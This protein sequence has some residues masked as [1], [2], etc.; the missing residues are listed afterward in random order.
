MFGSCCYVLESLDLVVPAAIETPDFFL[1]SIRTG[2]EEDPDIAEKQE[3][4][5]RELADEWKSSVPEDKH[6]EFE[7]V[8]ELG[9]RFFRMRDER[10]LATD[11]SGI[12]L[13]R[14]GIMEA[15]RRLA[16]Q[17]VVMK[18]EHL[19]VATKEEALSIL[20]GDFSL[21]AGGKKTVGTVEIPTPKELERRYEY[22]M[23][24]DPNLI[25]RALGVPVSIRIFPSHEMLDL[26]GLFTVLT[27]HCLVT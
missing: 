25:P 7:E 9:Q 10:G 18:P 4:K 16:E 3:K 11:L 26:A 6:A 20:R 2:L 12:G 19:T 24:A 5:V 27:I 22:I 23:S 15:G 1:S 14:R 21:L 8:F 17:G 13:C